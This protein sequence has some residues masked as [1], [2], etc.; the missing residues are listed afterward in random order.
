MAGADELK[1]ALEEPP[2]LEMHPADA[3]RLG[4]AD[5]ALATVRTEAGEAS[6]RVRV[7]D[8]I[9]RGSMFVPWNQPG[10]A[11]NTILSGR[12]TT[13]ASLHPAA[14]PAEVPS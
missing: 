6:L 12:S 8:G 14:A 5:G 9:A 3:E 7:T 1:A 2:F 13:R 11:A 10:F 4:V